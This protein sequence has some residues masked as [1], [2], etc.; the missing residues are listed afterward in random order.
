MLEQ[1]VPEVQSDFQG[2]EKIARKR[3]ETGNGDY[4]ADRP[5][6]SSQT[7]RGH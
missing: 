5:P 7:T 6:E 4:E 1:E 3:D 2:N